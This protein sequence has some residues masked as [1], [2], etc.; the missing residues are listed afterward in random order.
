MT[1]PVE[2]LL[3][4]EVARSIWCLGFWSDE[5]FTAYT[6]LTGRHPIQ[7]WGQA[8]E[9]W[10]VPAVPHALVEDIR[11]ILERIEA[12]WGRTL[13][14]VAEEMGTEADRLAYY[15]VM[16][17]MGHGIEPD[18]DGT[19]PDGLD[20]SPLNLDD[21]ADRYVPDVGDWTGVHDANDE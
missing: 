17:C 4:E 3:S 5:R 8:M 12:A 16:A 20:P 6:Q 7:A 10:P 13:D 18:D 21:P 14:D 1:M 9:Y 2:L 19:F 11:G 15:T